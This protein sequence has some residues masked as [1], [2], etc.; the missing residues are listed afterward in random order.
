MRKRVCKFF[1]A[2]D[3]EKEEAWLNQMALRG[4]ALVGVGPFSYVFE[5]GLPGEYEIREELLENL[6]SHPESQR[7]I[8][9]LEETGAEYVGSYLRWAFFRKKRTEGGFDLYS[10]ND[11]RAKHLGRIIALLTVIGLVGLGATLSNLTLFWLHRFPENLW[12]AMPTG[13]L[14]LFLLCGVLRLCR[15]RRQLKRERQ[16]FE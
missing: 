11:S 6:P 13:L 16:I 12:V 1:W 8:R 4:Q 7:Y 15:K 5:E 9:F 2:W 14:A 10:D 3:F